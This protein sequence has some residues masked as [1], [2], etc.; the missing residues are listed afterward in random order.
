MPSEGVPRSLKEKDNI[1]DFD[2]PVATSGVFMAYKTADI[3]KN[4]TVQELVSIFSSEFSTPFELSACLYYPAGGYMGWHTNSNQPGPRIYVSYSK[5]ANQNSFSYMKNGE[6][7]TDFDAQ[8]FTV[9]EFE[10]NNSNLFWHRVDAKIPRFSM[11]F[12]PASS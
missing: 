2:V 10:V 6:K 5:K 8:R 12:K 7:Y 3:L 4:K 11:G 9:R 1:P